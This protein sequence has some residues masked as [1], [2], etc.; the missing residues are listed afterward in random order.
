M[1]AMRYPELFEIEAVKQATDAD[2]KVANVAV[3]LCVTSYSLYAW[4]KRYGSTW[5]SINDTS[6][7]SEEIH[8]LN[9]EPNRATHE[10]DR[11]KKRGVLRK[12]LR[13][14]CAFI[15]QCG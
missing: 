13:V 14:R 4:I 7:E 10:R 8:R 2:H 3:R 15:K 12:P 5:R 11:L 6:S 1:S 9:K